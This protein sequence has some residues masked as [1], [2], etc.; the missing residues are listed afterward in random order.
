MTETLVEATWVGS[1]PA[2]LPDRR[3]LIS[4]KDTC[5]VGRH[6][7][8]TSDNWQIVEPPAP[9]TPAKTPAKADS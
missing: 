7:A 8:E 3:I 6:E 1:H 4:G 9:K 2:E 5:L